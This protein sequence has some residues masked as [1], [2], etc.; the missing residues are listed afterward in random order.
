MCYNPI[1]IKTEQGYK[2]VPCGHCLECLKKRQNEWTNRLNEQLK[3]AK[4]KAVFFTLTYDE[5][6]VPK[7]YF[8]GNFVYRSSPD[9]AYENATLKVYGKRVPKTKWVSNCRGEH[10]KWSELPYQ[11]LI[12]EGYDLPDK[13]RVMDGE[14]PDIV[15]FNLPRQNHNKF[16][17]E[18]QKEYGKYLCSFDSDSDFN[19]LHCE[20]SS[21]R[22]WCLN[23]FDNYEGDFFSTVSFDEEDNEMV[24]NAP[25]R[26]DSEASVMVDMFTNLVNDANTAPDYEQT[27]PTTSRI[28][29][30]NSVRKEDIQ[31]W[32]KASRQYAKRHDLPDF[33]YFIASEYGPRTLRPHYHGIL[34]GITA[35]EARPFFNYWKR[36]YGFYT[37]DN[38]NMSLGG[39]G[40]CCK[41]ACKG[42]Y[43]H[44]LCSRDFFYTKADG[45][46]T[47]YHSKHYERCIEIFG[48]DEP[49]VDKS[50]I[51]VSQGMGID[52]VTN[53]IFV[54]EVIDELHS[55]V[56]NYE[57][58]APT[59]T[60]N[61]TYA[62]WDDL[63]HTYE[64]QGY[65]KDEAGF[66]T[67]PIKIRKT[68][69]KVNYEE[70]IQKLYE[71]FK[72]FR[73]N[74]VDK[75]TY[76]YGMPKYYRAKMLDEGLRVAIAA[77]VQD[78]NVRV[79][80]QKLEELQAL[81]PTREDSENVVELEVQDRTERTARARKVAEQIKKNLNKSKL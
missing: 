46:L 32:I 58:V 68:E 65:P 61:M 37:A 18:I 41:Y 59:V 14:K 22:D 30:F 63:F 53:N 21:L 2:Q 40:Y 5:N 15:D 49:L 38:V 13:V 76:A 20:D 64:E 80:R 66:I 12:E 70:L 19:P 71:R 43:E 56:G 67:V 35:E 42:M 26:D 28:F 34:F 23:G 29:S 36:H 55:N 8:D 3:S 44:P 9:Y 73:Y 1:T 81:Y 60:Y 31:L 50:F 69:N 45:T 10:L 39:V 72:Y 25:W 77:Y 75:K 16:I 4:G 79:Y 17:E 74:P 52:Y 48:T 6:S 11:S 51:L 24:E 7:N 33:T 47:E 27:L 57:E 78:E 54:G 62:P